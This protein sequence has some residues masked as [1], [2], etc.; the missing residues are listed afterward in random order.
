MNRNAKGCRKILDMSAETDRKPTVDQVAELMVQIKRGRIKRRQLQEFIRDPEGL[1][2]LI[3][4]TEFPVLV[5]YDLPLEDFIRFSGIG[6]GSEDRVD[7]RCTEDRFPRKYRGCRKVVVE[8]FHIGRE[9]DVPTAKSIID[10]AGYRPAVIEELLALAIVHHD[11]QKRRV[12]LAVGSP[13]LEG[14][15]TYVPGIVGNG[16]GDRTLVLFPQSRFFKNDT[17]L[18]VRKEEN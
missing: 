5:N 16:F 14:N 13:S 15:E 7:D 2:E 17:Y 6:D 18:V 1:I 8:F 11:A 4:R 10:E 9:V 12:I 3:D